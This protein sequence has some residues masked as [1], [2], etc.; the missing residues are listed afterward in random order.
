MPMQRRFPPRSAAAFPALLLALFWSATARADPHIVVEVPRT[1][2]AIRIDADLDDWAGAVWIH[3][4]PDAPHVSTGWSS[5]LR[6]DGTEPEGTPLTSADLSGTFALRWDARHLYLA[7][8][9]TDNVHDT[10][11]DDP[12][13]WYCRDAVSL[14][15]DVPFDGDG[16][17]WIAGDHAFCF[18]ASPDLPQQHWWRHGEPEGHREMPLPEDIPVA[19]TLTAVGYDLEAA[20]P[21]DLLTS[22]GGGGGGGPLSPTT[23]PASPSWSP[24]RTAALTLLEGS[25]ST[26]AKAMMTVAGR[27]SASLLPATYPLLL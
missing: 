17:G 8:S 21:M 2:I 15:L 18:V 25:C 26:A 3:L 10:V 4:A 7:A 19:V 13:R 24:T 14:F 16:S 27:S 1:E 20:I 9:I 6:D 23:P 11:D 5:R 22:L 12:S